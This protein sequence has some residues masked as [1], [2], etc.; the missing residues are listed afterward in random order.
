MAEEDEV[1]NFPKKKYEGLIRHIDEQNITIDEQNITIDDKNAI[2]EKKNNEIGRL[3]EAL[4]ANVAGSTSIKDDNSKLNKEY[5]I[6]LKEKE[7]LEDNL[8]KLNNENY[9]LTTDLG[10]YGEMR[11]KFGKVADIEEKAKKYENEIKIKNEE[12][13]D[14]TDITTKQ[15]NK[16]K[17]LE[18]A[19]KSKKRA[20]TLTAI[21]LGAGLAATGIFG[22][23]QYNRAEKAEA[24]L[25]T[26]KETIVKEYR[27]KYEKEFENTWKKRE[28]GLRS[29]YK[30]R[31]NEL[32]KVKTD[33]LSIYEDVRARKY[34]KA[35][36]NIGKAKKYIKRIEK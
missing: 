31:I 29:G 28:T 23:W 24:K 30:E 2:I 7:K 34:E 12:I 27:A 21:L 15:L 9:K 16:N 33:A 25:K 11:E 18:K 19:V 17:E 4:K 22:Y 1:V 8:K 20:L 6:V 36:L 10:K 5:S 32:E 14:L 35:A 13:V 26:S 3:E